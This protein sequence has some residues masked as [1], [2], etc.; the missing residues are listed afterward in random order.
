MLDDSPS[1][2]AVE[3]TQMSF[4]KRKAPKGGNRG[5][6]RSKLAS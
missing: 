3:K 5:Q 6:V 4:K 1:L 2:G